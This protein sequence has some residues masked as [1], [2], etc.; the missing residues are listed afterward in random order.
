MYDETMEYLKQNE[1]YSLSRFGDSLTDGLFI[2]RIDQDGKNR[3]YIYEYIN[4]AGRE[5]THLTKADVGRSMIECFSQA[6]AKYL[7]DQYERCFHKGSIVT[8]SDSVMLPNGQ[9]NAQTNLIPVLDQQNVMTHVVGI[10][11]N[12]TH[13]SLKTDEVRHV[14]RLFETYMNQTEEALIMLDMNQRILN[15]NQAFYDL[16]EYEKSYIQNKRLEDLQPQIAE[17]VRNQ[18]SYLNEGKNITHYKAEWKKKSGESLH[19]S[20]NFTTLPDEHG[21]LVAVVAVIQNITEEVRAKKA[22][23]DSEHRYRLIANYTQ[24]LV[25]LIEIDGTIKYASPSHEPVLNY[26]PEELYHTNTFQYIH[27]DDREKVHKRFLY[28]IKQKK[29]G[30]VQF[31]MIMKDGTWIWFESNVKPVMGDDGEV[32]HIVSSSRDISKRKKAEDQLKRLAYTDHLTGLANRRILMQFLNKSIAKSK[33]NPNKKVSLLYLDGDGFKNINDTLGHDAGDTVLVKLSRRLLKMTREED[34]VSRIGG[35]EFV[36]LLPDI[37][38]TEQAEH[39]AKRILE[40]MNLPFYVDD[41]QI[42]I[43]VSIGIGI[44]PDHANNSEDLF[45]RA[46][47]ALYEAKRQGKKTYCVA[48]S[49]HNSF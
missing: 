2:M 16:F 26:K 38:S 44:S 35:D 45:K 27:Q 6:E 3:R 18:F 33:R 34:I 24:D 25:K 32:T 30:T 29:S 36:I 28:I 43:T 8:Y 39:V 13:L 42:N 17:E 14:N 1:L 20:I 41:E 12:L 22:L 11:R 10:T 37:Q 48:S 5:I 31:R 46:D 4:E 7:I 49:S 23:S 40:E 47:E 21:K 19:L 9:F 15:V